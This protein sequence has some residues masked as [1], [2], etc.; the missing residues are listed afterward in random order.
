MKASLHPTVL[1]G[2]P[3]PA[4]HP[5]GAAP[6]RADREVPAVALRTLQLGLGWFP[7][8]P[9]GL[10]RY[11]YEL[12]SRLPAHGVGVEGLVTGTAG[13]DGGPEH[14]PPSDPADDVPSD[15]AADVPAR[16]P[17]AAALRVRS[18]I[19]THAALWRR[20]RAF[21]SAAADALVN[22]PPDVVAAHFALY[23]RPALRRLK[24]VPLVVH[25]Q[26]PWAAESRIEGS[27]RFAAAAKRAVERGVYRR[28]DRLIVLSEAFGDLL[29][30]G[31]GVDPARVRVIPG[32][33]DAGR[34]DIPESR[35]EA[36]DRLGWPADRPVAL[37]VRRLVG[38]MGLEDLI[39]AAALLRRR[40]PDAL[41]LIAGRGRLGPALQARIDAAGLQRHVR[42]LGFVP[43][44][45]LPLAYRA[46][47]L[48][49]LPTTALEG[50]GLAAAESLAAGT[51]AVV[52]PV[53]GLPE[54]VAG[55]GEALLLPAPGPAALADRLAELLAADRPLPAALPTAAACREHAG[56]F[57]WSRVV[58]RV[59]DVYCRAHEAGRP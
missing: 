49:V 14:H 34:F 24:G 8:Q 28:A 10:E 41:V 1:D 29:C 55:L 6:T 32:A 20:L 35:R 25:F 15:P 37:S 17:G 18:V 11:Y 7:E 42:L 23:A 59:R 9:G 47:D 39:D 4:T 31:Y 12:V 54:V 21:D 16:R 38:R 51:P 3:N 52:T 50:F 43:D 27:G 45:D 57:D 13:L 19:G 53:G 2:P 40:V 26:G 22:R 30:R 33:I 44:D 46:A 36:R 56:R 5:A 48:S 58:P